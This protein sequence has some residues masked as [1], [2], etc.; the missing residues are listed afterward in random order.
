[1]ALALGIISSGSFFSYPVY[2]FTHDFNLTFYNT[3]AHD[4]FF[5]KV[6]TVRKV[7]EATLQ[8]VDG[9]KHIL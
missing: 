1:M 9:V 2:S 5:K 4:I 3:F 7:N 8:I 6:I